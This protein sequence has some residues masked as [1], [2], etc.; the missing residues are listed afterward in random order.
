MLTGCTFSCCRF[1]FSRVVGN[2]SVLWWSFLAEPYLLS[3]VEEGICTPVKSSIIL[4]QSP[5]STKRRG[6]IVGPFLHSREH[7]DLECRWTATI[8]PILHQKPFAPM[9]IHPTDRD[10]Y[11]S[12]D[13]I[14]KRRWADCD[15][16]T[17]IIVENP[18]SQ[19]T[20]MSKL[21]QI[22]AAVSG[23]FS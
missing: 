5:H 23:R 22:L 13:S 2:G 20:C 7:M 6:R 14:D 1:F 15:G 3:R 8:L 19:T 9:C 4:R 10:R 11:V 16:L 17:P 18:S 12:G 21:V